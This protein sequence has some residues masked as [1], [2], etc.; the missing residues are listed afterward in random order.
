MDKITVVVLADPTEP[1]LAM[2]E[3]LPPDTGIAVGN[4]AEAFVRA[5]PEAVEIPTP[6]K[7]GTASGQP[8]DRRK[9]GRPAIRT[10]A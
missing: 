3:A 7:T 9:P 2:L 10:G 1:Q 5:A 4:Q 6:P 8:G